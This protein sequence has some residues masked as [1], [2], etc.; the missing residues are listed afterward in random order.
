MGNSNTGTDPLLDSALPTRNTLK[1]R[2]AKAAYLKPDHAGVGWAAPAPVPPA[3]IGD[4]P[5]VLYSQSGD[6]A[7]A[8]MTRRLKTLAVRARVLLLSGQRRGV[9]W[10]PLRRLR[11][12]EWTRKGTLNHPHL[13]CAG[14]VSS[15]SWLLYTL[16]E[17]A[18]RN[19]RVTQK[20]S[21]TRQK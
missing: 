14:P 20:L 2:T 8:K 9:G 7:D 4:G 15:T 11:V 19:T 16:N 3:L 5:P 6:A 17:I 13:A 10:M 1:F 21:M 18:K 12:M